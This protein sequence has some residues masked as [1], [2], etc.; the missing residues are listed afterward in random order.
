M[1]S[2]PV[3]FS[4]RGSFFFACVRESFCS[5]PIFSLL[6]FKEICNISKDTDARRNGNHLLQ[7]LSVFKYRRGINVALPSV[8]ADERRRFL[9]RRIHLKINAD[10]QACIAH[11]GFP[12]FEALRRRWIAR[13]KFLSASQ[14]FTPQISLKLLQT[15]S[16]TLVK[17][18]KYSE[19]PPHISIV[20]D[21]SPD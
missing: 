15:F 10:S 21:C 19:Q 17:E 14:P 6:F 4:Y 13:L 9:C 20:K 8:Q 12:C 1:S 3:P 18:P 7:F 2:I 16:R 5:S 11:S